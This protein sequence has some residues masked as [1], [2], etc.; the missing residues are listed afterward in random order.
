MD[1]IL[2]I[3]QLSDHWDYNASYENFEVCGLLIKMNCNY[4]NLVKMICNEL[5]LRLN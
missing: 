5:N 1:N 3:L 4:S 2:I